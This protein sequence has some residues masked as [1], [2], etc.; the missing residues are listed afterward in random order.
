MILDGDLEM[1]QDKP[2]AKNIL[3]N[4]FLKIKRKWNGK[5]ETETEVVT[6]HIL[7]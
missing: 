2:A 6:F 3:G 5:I 4:L 1:C 7:I